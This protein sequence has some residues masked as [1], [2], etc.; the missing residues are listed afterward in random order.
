MPTIE[1]DLT[2]AEKKEKKNI[3]VAIQDQARKDFE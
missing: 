3:E 2:V 1:G